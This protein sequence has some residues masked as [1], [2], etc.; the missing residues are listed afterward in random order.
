[1][2]A[3]RLRRFRTKG[4]VVGAPPVIRA[5]MFAA[6]WTDR[7]RRTRLQQI[8]GD[9]ASEPE[10]A[11]DGRR[12]GEILGRLRKGPWVVS[13]VDAMLAAV[14]ERTPA[15]V[16]TDDLQDFARM[17]EESGAAATFLSV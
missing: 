9:L 5:E 15:V 16:L 10:T 7:T 4:D 12:A 2:L 11:A 3:L 6:V 1:M 17:R 8:L 13:L 14:A